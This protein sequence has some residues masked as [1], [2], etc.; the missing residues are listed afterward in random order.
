MRLMRAIPAL[1]VGAGLALAVAPA[2]SAGMVTVSSGRSS[3]TLDY[4]AVSG[5]RNQVF[6]SGSADSTGALVFTV[7]EESPGFQVGPGC[8]R[9]SDSTADCTLP[10]GAEA[11]THFELGDRSDR[12]YFADAPVLSGRIYGGRGDDRLEAPGYDGQGGVPGWLDLADV[13]DLRRPHGA[14]PDA[15]APG[16]VLFGGSGR[17]DL[18]GSPRDDVLRPGADQ[19]YVEA[20]GGSD[21]II[22]REGSRD[23]IA[24][25]RRDAVIADRL[26]FPFGQRCV[27]R[28]RGAF[29]PIPL[30]A[31]VSDTGGLHLG[32]S[33]GCAT[34][35]PRPCAGLVTA[36]VR[37]GRRVVSRR[38]RILP[39]RV[40][41]PTRYIEDSTARAVIRRGL[42]VT[43]SS[44]DT[45]GHARVVS[46][47]IRVEY[48]LGPN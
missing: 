43:V 23:V 38:F 18:R 5:E 47:A 17:D 15:S 10:V 2:A 28:R 21:Q 11:R 3:A 31:F 4:R 29:A 30:G 22:A 19:D 1:V 48:S 33:V 27:V 46:R 12:L 13:G 16:S 6:V 44:I 24:C 40:G 14:A 26:D 37:G 9:T 41:G 34:D 45:A 35:A 8:V 20:R 39:G 42:R 7:S 36:S 25:D 32:L